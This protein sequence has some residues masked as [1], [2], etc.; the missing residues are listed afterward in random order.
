M[1]PHRLSRLER[2]LI[3]LIAGPLLSA[4][5]VTPRF[6]PLPQLVPIERLLANAQRQRHDNPE[7]AEAHYLVA[8]LHYLVFSTGWTMVR[9]QEE[10]Q[11][12]WDGATNLW[13]I[14][15]RKAEELAHEDVGAFGPN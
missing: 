8:R 14:R 12:R 5:I 3:V 2:V 13:Q 4:F 11:V 9:E 15:R 6:P 7:S 10:L 1:K